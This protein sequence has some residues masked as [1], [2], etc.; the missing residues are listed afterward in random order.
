MHCDSL[1]EAI[2]ELKKQGFQYDFNIDK[3]LIHCTA[4]NKDFQ[5]E[6]FQVAFHQIFDDGD[7]AGS[8]SV[9][10]ALATEDGHKGILIDAYGTYTSAVAT[11]L[12]ENISFKKHGKN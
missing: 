1:T 12:L 2:N 4:L 6:D 11:K 5:T 10:Y 8:Q 9:I 3:E 7:D